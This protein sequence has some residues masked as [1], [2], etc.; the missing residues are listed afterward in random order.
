MKKAL[1]NLWS[2]FSRPT[3]GRLYDFYAVGFHGDHYLIELTKTCLSQAEQYME[4]GANV[5]STLCYVARSYPHVVAY[6]CEPDKRAYMTASRH[7]HGCDNARLLN[8]ASPNMFYELV[9]SDDA[10]LERET[11]FWLDAHCYGFPW[12]LLDEIAFV[13]RNFLKGFIFIDDFKVPGLECFRFF[14]EQRGECSFEYI[15]DALNP[16]R[17][18]RLYYPTYQEKTSPHHPLCGWGMIE[19]GHAQSIALP[20]SLQSKTRMEHIIGDTEG[21]H[22]VRT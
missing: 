15:R 11:V 9:K 4:T 18:Y 16:A 21:R 12:P 19:F 7:L 10:L 20:P 22:I 3:Q 6:A 14:V 8:L 2:V 5:G 17:T 1:A 13:T